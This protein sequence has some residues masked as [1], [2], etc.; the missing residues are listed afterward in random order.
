[1]PTEAA[2]TVAENDGSCRQIR[3]IDST[4]IIVKLN[5]T[6]EI[7]VSMNRCSAFS[8]PIITV[9]GPTNAKNGIIS[10]ASLT[11]SCSASR[12]ANPGAS[13]E[14]TSGI[15]TKRT[16]AMPIRITLMLPSTR[17]ANAAAAILP[18]VSRNRR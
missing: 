16:S 8:T 15:S 10:R 17:P 2:M 6:G 18:S 13:S 11:A 12:P 5:S 4:E 9:T 3:S 14:I 7:A 1:M